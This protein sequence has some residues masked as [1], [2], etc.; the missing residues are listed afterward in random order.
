MALTT[1]P[2]IVAARQPKPVRAPK[3]ESIARIVHAPSQKTLQAIARWER[4]TG[5]TDPDREVESRSD[6]S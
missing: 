5:R 2:C 6:V 1:S 3:P 4:L